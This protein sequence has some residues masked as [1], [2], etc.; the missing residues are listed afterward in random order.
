M[1]GSPLIDA[2]AKAL[3]D[4]GA[5]AAAQLVRDTDPEDDLWNNY[6]GP[7][8]DEL[9]DDYTKIAKEMSDEQQQ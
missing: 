3:E 6:I 2:V 9:E 7:M 8:L 5:T 1:S 4:R